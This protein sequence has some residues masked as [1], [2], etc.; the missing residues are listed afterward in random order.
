MSSSFDQSNWKRLSR[1]EASLNEYITFLNSSQVKDLYFWGFSAVTN[2][3]RGEMDVWSDGAA[4]NM[5]ESL[6]LLALAMALCL[7]LT[8]LPFVSA[9]I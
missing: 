9:C 6:D 1:F 5:A 4:K 2:S 8:H 7:T 3:G